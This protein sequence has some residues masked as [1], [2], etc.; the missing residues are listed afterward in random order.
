M[1]KIRKKYVR[2]C[3][4]GFSR[5]AFANFY[6]FAANELRPTLSKLLLAGVSVGFAVLF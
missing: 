6:T 2:Y 1:P 3:V 5:Y 4:Y